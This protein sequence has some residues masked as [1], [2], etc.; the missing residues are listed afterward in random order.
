MLNGAL[1]VWG[2]IV[3]Y[4]RGEL[5]VLRKGAFEVVESEWVMMMRS[6]CDRVLPNAKPKD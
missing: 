2:S 1:G 3:E 5:L 6:I 4:W